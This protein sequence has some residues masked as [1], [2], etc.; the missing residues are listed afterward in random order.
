MLA[1]CA[2]LFDIDI[3]NKQTN[4]KLIKYRMF[5]K[6]MQLNLPN[7]THISDNYIRNSFEFEPVFFHFRLLLLLSKKLNHRYF[8]QCLI[9]FIFHFDYNLDLQRKPK[10]KQFIYFLCHLYINIIINNKTIKTMT[11]V[12]V[13][14]FYFNSRQYIEVS[15]VGVIVPN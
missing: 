2:K 8:F 11:D 14:T 3:F 12:F 9:R 4:K 5:W 13:F 7:M 10:T 1:K 6:K 15:Q